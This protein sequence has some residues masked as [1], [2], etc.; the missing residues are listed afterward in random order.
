MTIYRLPPQDPSENKS[1]D[2]NNK[3]IE[4]PEVI[5]I[6]PDTNGEGRRT[7]IHP[8]KNVKASIFLSLIFGVIGICAAIWAVVLLCLTLIMCVI[9][10]CFLFK[11]PR[12]NAILLAF[13]KLTKLVSAIATGFIIAVFSLSLGLTLILI[14]LSGIDES[15]KST[16]FASTVRSYA[17]NYTK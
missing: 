1:S 13:W 12:M 8:E 15:L 6:D 9:S 10:G 14:Y 11:N 7:T 17:K 16:V 5:I 3:H 4:E 2:S